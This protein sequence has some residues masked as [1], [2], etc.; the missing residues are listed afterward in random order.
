MESSGKP[1]TSLRNY[2]SMFKRRMI[3]KSEANSRLKM[4]RDTAQEHYQAD[5]ASLLPPPSE[6]SGISSARRSRYRVRRDIQSHIPDWIDDVVHSQLMEI[7]H[8]LGQEE[9]YGDGGDGWAPIRTSDSAGRT[10]S[11]IDDVPEEAQD[12]TQERSPEEVSEEP[13]PG[14][15][16]E[17]SREEIHKD[18]HSIAMGRRSSVSAPSTRSASI[19]RGPRSLVSPVDETIIGPISFHDLAAVREVKSEEGPSSK[20]RRRRR[21]RNLS[22][23]SGNSALSQETATSNYSKLSS[24]TSPGTSADKRISDTLSTR[25][26]WTDIAK[27][28]PIKKPVEAGMMKKVNTHLAKPSTS[29][30][31]LSPVNAGVFDDSTSHKSK[32]STGYSVKSPVQAGVMEGETSKLNKPLP[33][34]PKQKAAERR[35]T[36]FV[37]GDI[38][39]SPRTPQSPRLPRSSTYPS[40]VGM[41]QSPH[42][43]QSPKSARVRQS[44]KSS[45]SPKLSHSPQLLRSPVDGPSE[46]VSHKQFARLSRP[47]IEPVFD[48]EDMPPSPGLVHWAGSPASMTPELNEKF[49]VIE[50]ETSEAEQTHIGRNM[51]S[52]EPEE[53]ISTT[54]L[55][56][57]ETAKIE[58][59]PAVQTS[60]IDERRLSTIEEVTSPM[61]QPTKAEALGLGISG[62]DDVPGT[63]PA[64]TVQ[65][66]EDLPIRSDSTLSQASRS[67]PTEASNTPLR[68]RSTSPV[69]IQQIVILPPSRPSTPKDAG[70]VC[71][72]AAQATEQLDHIAQTEPTEPTNDLLTSVAEEDEIPI[73]LDSPIPEDEDE[74]S[75]SET[76]TSAPPS[77]TLSQAENDLMAQLDLPT[78]LDLDT[79]YKFMRDSS[80]LA[81]DFA[82]SLTLEQSS[83]LDHSSDNLQNF[84][85]LDG[86]IPTFHIESTRPATALGNEIFT[87]EE[88]DGET[89]EAMLPIEEQVVRPATALGNEFARE[90]EGATTRKKT[91]SHYEFLWSAEEGW[92]VA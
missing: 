37:V 15:A 3:K 1:R 80:W 54:Q 74:T 89:R 13:R 85:T 60:I 19:L 47:F 12:G 24:V 39:H 34:D 51:V 58:S 62:M 4:G 92:Y 59:E 16:P 14:S 73:V 53:D 67:S 43:T 78:Q 25:M 77:P 21:S 23:A 83:P 81:G 82:E 36:F 30:S 65:V 9:T 68:S 46:G 57:A 7:A 29:Y 31:I 55:H 79:S 40:S 28:N 56:T 75:L 44:P 48:F 10:E 66:E 42:A 72:E 84:S 26:T 90:R 52:I 71:I 88:A 61:V 91:E 2:T 27:K 38:V 18:A 6:S 33:P 49:L 86:G 8:R 87:D 69:L 32:S 5:N 45:R 41:S 64:D 11:P 50:E 76:D 20:Q 35:T 22:S 17:A 70:S 63:T